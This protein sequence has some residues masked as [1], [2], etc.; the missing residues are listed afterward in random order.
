MSSVESLRS[1]WDL[2]SAADDRSYS[3]GPRLGYVTRARCNR[4]G[5]KY[6]L[7]PFSQKEP[8]GGSN[9]DVGESLGPSQFELTHSKS[10]ALESL[11]ASSS[12]RYRTT[13]VLPS[14]SYFIY[15]LVV[16]LSV[17]WP[18][19][20]THWWGIGV[21]LSHM[22]YLRNLRGILCAMLRDRHRHR[23]RCLLPARPYSSPY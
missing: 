17:H 12:S 11:L 3:D 9:D 6:S 18:S 2:E 4:R 14:S 1:Y 22:R 10:V 19:I 7:K 16:E 8:G 23:H 15:S 21:R 20:R 5:S 13:L